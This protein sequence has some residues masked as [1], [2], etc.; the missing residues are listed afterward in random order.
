MSP[1]DLTAYSYME[2][3][4]GK[5]KLS[6]FPVLLPITAKVVQKTDFGYRNTLREPLFATL[7][8]PGVP[9]Q[10]FGLDFYASA[11][12]SICRVDVVC[13]VDDQRV[14][15]LTRIEVSVRGVHTEYVA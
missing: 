11:T 7:L 15:T 1:A 9:K 2:V 8:S 5:P 12:K 6:L 3:A 14:V 4:Q 13:K 10:L